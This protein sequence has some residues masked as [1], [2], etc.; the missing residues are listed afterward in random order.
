MKIRLVEGHNAHKGFEI[1]YVLLW[2]DGKPDFTTLD[3]VRVRKCLEGRLCGIC[4]QKISP[5]D[6]LAYVGGSNS[7]VFKDPHNHQECAIRAFAKCPFLKGERI[8]AGL[9]ARYQDSGDYYLF[10]SDSMA[11]D[12]ET[13]DTSLKGHCTMNKVQFQRCMCPSSMNLHAGRHVPCTVD[14]HTGD[15]GQCT[16]NVYDEIVDP[17]KAWCGECIQANKAY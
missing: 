17:D 6:A 12:K 8:R 11:W 15:E 4:G 7:T 3:P 9:P 16:N 10:L 5:K 1:P 2:R 13:L 14:K